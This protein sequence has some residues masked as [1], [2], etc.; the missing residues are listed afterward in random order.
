MAS[1]SSEREQS[2]DAMATA[3][4]AAHFAARPI[5]DAIQAL[6]ARARRLPTIV[7]TTNDLDVLDARVVLPTYYDGVLSIANAQLRSPIKA[8]QDTLQ[9]VA[10]RAVQSA[11]PQCIPF[12]LLCSDEAT[13]AYASVERLEGQ[14]AVAILLFSFIS[15]THRRLP[16]AERLAVWFGLSASEASL[17]ID[18]AQGLNVNEIAMQRGLSQLTIRTHLRSIFEKTNTHKQRDLVALLLRLATI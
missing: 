12:R 16:E 6:T 10:R 1:L 4:S 3:L 18:F 7:L 15:P 11:A 8:N 9:H 2:A 5:A 14:H 17:S 13:A